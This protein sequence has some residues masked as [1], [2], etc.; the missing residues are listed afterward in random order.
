MM[1]SMQRGK[2]TSSSCCSITTNN[3]MLS[4]ATMVLL[5]LCTNSQSK[6]SFHAMPTVDAFSFTTNPA[7]SIV[8]G[9]AGSGGSGGTIRS[10]SQTIQFTSSFKVTQFQQR[11]NPATRHIPTFH[12][13]NT[14]T[15]MAATAATTSNDDGEE[16]M[17]LSST[18]M[19]DRASLLE[20]AFD[21]MDDRDKY[22]AVLTGLCSKILDNQSNK[23]GGGDATTAAAA[24]DGVEKDDVNVNDIAED[25]TLTPTQL[26]MKTMKDPIRLMQE[27]NA[28][29]VKASSRS[30][31]ALIDVSFFPLSI[32]SILD[33]SSAMQNAGLICSLLTVYSTAVFLFYC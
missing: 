17:V 29:K 7:A 27:M 5:V 20:S 2:R 13:G 33:V 23:N 24:A 10:T 28:S 22:D 8:S 1:M 15:A 14:N 21:A 18:F 6:I 19:K 12:N 3:R 4:V 26:A 9:A 11:R 30:L 31:M 32:F 16:G 25:A